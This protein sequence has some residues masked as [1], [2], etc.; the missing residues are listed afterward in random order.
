MG[1]FGTYSYVFDSFMRMF[2]KGYK[3]IVIKL[4][5]SPV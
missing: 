4:C 5:K 2:Y 3:P 1:E